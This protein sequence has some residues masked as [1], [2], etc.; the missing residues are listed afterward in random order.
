MTTNRPY[1]KGL[2]V[3][4][5]IGELKKFSGKQFDPLCVEAFLRAFDK[6]LFQYFEK[7]DGTDDMVLKDDEQDA[8]D[9]ADGIHGELESQPYPPMAAHEHKTSEKKEKADS[10]PEKLESQPYPP[11]VPSHAEPDKPS[12]QPFPPISPEDDEKKN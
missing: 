1:R 5:A 4:T 7:V 3:K 6:K 11:V 10:K 8:K 2:T 9:P 12:S